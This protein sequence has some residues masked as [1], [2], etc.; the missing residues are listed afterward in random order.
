MENAYLG[1]TIANSCYR[2]N[3]HY[4]EGMRSLKIALALLLTVFFAGGCTTPQAKSIESPAKKT[5]EAKGWKQMSEGLLYKEIH[6]ESTIQHKQK[7]I[8]VVTIDPKKFTFEIYE[9][10]SSE[11]AKTIK[12]IG[13]ETGAQLTFN[14]GFFTEKF[15]PTGLLL[16]K[17][18]KLR[19]ISNAGLL[20]GVF[21]IAENGQAEL[22]D[23]K[24]EIKENQY[25]FAIQN[26]PI[27]L[28]NEGQININQETGKSA[29]RTVIGIDKNQN[30]VVIIL[31][32]SLL[33]NDNTISLYELAHLLSEAPE[34]KEMGLHSVLNLDGGVSTGI[35]LGEKYYPEMERVQNVILVKKK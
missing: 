11:E 19:D 34:L 25:L 23:Q 33:N 12:E 24:A 5:E 4:T 10:S 8:I 14:G 9:N 27:I 3:I 18:K 21:T 29:S 20:E 31:K 6:L 35:M 32:Q 16:S 30:I 22:L 17:G 28:N 7:D 26:G 13:E 1:E 2:C 15:K